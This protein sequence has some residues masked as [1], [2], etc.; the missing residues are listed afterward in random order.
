M[1]WSPG[2]TTLCRQHRSI[3]RTTSLDCWIQSTALH[4]NR[5][6][7]IKQGW[8]S[9]LSGRSCLPWRRTWLFRGRHIQVGGR[10]GNGK[11]MW[12]FRLPLPPVQYQARWP[13]PVPATGAILLMRVNHPALAL[14]SRE[15]LPGQAWCASPR[16]ALTGM[17]T[18]LPALPPARTGPSPDALLPRHL[19]RRSGAPRSTMEPLTWFQGPRRREVVRCGLHCPVRTALKETESPVGLSGRCGFTM[20]VLTVTSHSV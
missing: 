3:N 4:D 13:Y 6:S 9:L 11:R 17:R 14:L 7:L 18:C 1:P 8:T 12:S 19:R 5:M 16:R 20:P 10:E 15:I 2:P